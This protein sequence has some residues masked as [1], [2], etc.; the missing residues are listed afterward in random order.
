MKI[1][2]EP[3]VVIEPATLIGNLIP[4]NKLTLLTGLPGTGKSYSVVKFLNKEGIKPIVLNLDN[5]PFPDLDV[6][7]YD[8]LV[9]EKQYKSK[10]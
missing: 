7:S 1:A 6:F 3:L 8:K 10:S 2:D 4:S 5:A 9:F